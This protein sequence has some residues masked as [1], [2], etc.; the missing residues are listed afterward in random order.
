MTSRRNLIVAGAVLALGLSACAGT[1]T[2]PRAAAPSPNAVGA[3]E[4]P[5]VA[6]A[7]KPAAGKAGNPF[8]GAAS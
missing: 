7:T 6:A 5:T 3:A 2:A 8:P 1:P 4:A